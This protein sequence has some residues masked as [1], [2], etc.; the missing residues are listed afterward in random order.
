VNHRLS[1]L[2]SSSKVRRTLVVMH[3][4]LSDKGPHQSQEVVV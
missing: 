2:I 1:E 4:F 3:S